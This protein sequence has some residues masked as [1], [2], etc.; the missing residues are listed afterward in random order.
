MI[1]QDNKSPDWF[2]H[3]YLGTWQFSGNFKHFS[4]CQ[5]EDLL[6]FAW[7]NGF[8]NFDTAAVYGNGKVESILGEVLPPESFIV[9]KIPAISKPSLEVANSISLYYPFDWINQNVENS[10][11]RLKRN[12]LN[13]VLLHNWSRSWNNNSLKPLLILQDLKRQKL[14]ERIGISL[15]D[16][17]NASLPQE[18][19]DVTDVIEAPYNYD[20]Q[21][22]LKILEQKNIQTKEIIIRSLFFQGIYFLNHKKI[23]LLEPQDIR[24]KKTNHCL[25]AKNNKISASEIIKNASMLPVSIVVGMTTKEQITENISIIKEVNQ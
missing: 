15:P 12:K 5:V 3:F 9:T 24:R 7:E 22:I 8:K 23:N 13:T 6:I 19:I 2:N 18:V 20:N 17:F 4:D 11:K 1:Y 21:W 14:I 10:L 16:D 25:D